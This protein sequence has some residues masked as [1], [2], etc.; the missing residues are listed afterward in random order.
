MGE[1]TDLLQ[2]AQRG[3]PGAVDRLFGLLYGDLR[4]AARRQLRRHDYHQA[5]DTTLLVNESYLRMR[6]RAELRSADR[7]KFLAYAA[8]AMRSVIVDLA[9]QRLSEK[10]GGGDAHITLVTGIAE[11][12]GDQDLEVVRV[13]EALE[14]LHAIEPRLAKIV[15]LRF[16]GGLNETEVG[17]VLG[18]SKRTVQRDWEKARA[19]LYTSLQKS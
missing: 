16:F 12:F 3:E 14:E 1:L 4:S 19:L 9:R 15:E 2:A 5:L 7:Q 17:E 6:D 18:L 13:N 8:A 11:S 10:R